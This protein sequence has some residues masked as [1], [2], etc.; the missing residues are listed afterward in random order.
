MSKKKFEC[1]HIGHGKYCHRC[2]QELAARKIEIDRQIDGQNRRNNWL[3]TFEED[4]ISLKNI[5]DKECVLRKARSIIEKI[6][7]GVPIHQLRG[8][9]IKQCK[10]IVSIPVGRDYRLIYRT[11]STGYAAECVLSHEQYNSYIRQN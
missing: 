2:E 8:K 9:H 5:Q 4:S 10:N 6:T 1:G 7:N 11:T 3:R